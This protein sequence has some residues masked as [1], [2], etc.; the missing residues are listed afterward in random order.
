MN[1]SEIDFTRWTVIDEDGRPHMGGALPRVSAIGDWFPVWDGSDACPIVPRDQWKTQESLRPYEWRDI[2]QNGYPACCLAAT[3]NAI[4]LHL[5]KTGRAKTP[6]D[7]LKAWRTLSGG[8]G[9]VAIDA[10][11]RYIMTNGMPLADGSGVLVVRE[12]WDAPTIESFV[13]GLQ[14]GC[15]GVYGH[16]V[17]A[18]CG[19]RLV[20]EGGAAYVDT[21][22][23][24]GRNWGDQGWHLFPA[25]KIEIRLYG[26]YLIR[27][28]ELRPA[29][30]DGLIDARG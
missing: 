10:A 18:E 27:E 5:A 30:T 21:R 8:R 28:V 29:D 9:G 16:D 23:S 15:T 12:V 3:A 20:M 22:N 1:E 19:T 2:D 4:E 11:L 17:H 24:W 25:S 26:A 13:S 7:W 14:R 6:L